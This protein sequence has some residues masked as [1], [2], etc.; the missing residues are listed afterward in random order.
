MSEGVRGLGFRMEGV[1]S[2]HFCPNQTRYNN[3]R[4]VHPSKR[5]IFGKRQAV[6]DILTYSPPSVDKIWGIW[7]FSY[8]IYKAIFYLLKRDYG[9][10]LEFGG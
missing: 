4:N 6:S 7:G 5:T 10:C 2:G 8:S 9:F 3:P 1:R